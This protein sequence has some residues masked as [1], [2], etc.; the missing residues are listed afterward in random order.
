MKFNLSLLIFYTQDWPSEK[1]MLNNKKRKEE[2]CLLK[3]SMTTRRKVA[4]VKTRLG[5]SIKKQ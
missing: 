3:N 1:S 2:S 4:S 5:F